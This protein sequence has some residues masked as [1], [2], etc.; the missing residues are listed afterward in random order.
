MNNITPHRYN[1]IAITLHW[2]MAIG[3]IGMLASGLVLE[4]ATLEKSLTFKL[5][6]WHKASGLL[7]LAAVVLRILWRLVSAIKDDIP[8]L[9][10]S[11]PKIEKIAAKLGHLG[12]YAVMIAMPITG[13][14]MVSSSVYGL[15][16]IIFG[17]FE[18]P[19]IPGVASNESINKSSKLAHAWI[20]WAFIALIAAHIAA[21]IKHAMI[22]QE[23]LLTCMWW[24]KK[25]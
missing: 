4:Y 11:F 23:N 3:F 6:Q 15:P 7:L 8:K 16:T 18:W 25:G 22:D 17:W 24:S 19:H 9:P 21:V 13:W 20:A 10:D 12:L 2:L 1:S 14:L 5:F